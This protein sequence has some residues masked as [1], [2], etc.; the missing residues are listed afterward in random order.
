MPYKNSDVVAFFL[1]A[2]P[3]LL[4][5]LAAI[6]VAGRLLDGSWA[7]VRDILKAQA[8]TPGIMNGGK[9][10]EK[11]PSAIERYRLVLGVRIALLTMGVAFVVI[12]IF[13]G[14]AKDV[15]DKAVKLCMECIG[16]G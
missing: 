14:G 1:L 5:G 2:I 3:L 9:T 8:K 7:R 6:Y 12:G 13:N 4:V 11:K 16:L 15:Y 10:E